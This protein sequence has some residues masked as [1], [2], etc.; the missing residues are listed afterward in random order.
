MR[1]TSSIGSDSGGSDRIDNIINARSATDSRYDARRKAY[2]DSLKK[3]S[4]K[5]KA[6][7]A[8]NKGYIVDKYGDREYM[9]G[10]GRTVSSYMIGNEAARRKAE[11]MRNLPEP[12]VLRNK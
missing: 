12:T 11:A 6:T 2:T 9:A 1:R 7:K 4:T 10:G 8:Q 5:K 3:S